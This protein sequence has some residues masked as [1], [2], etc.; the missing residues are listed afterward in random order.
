MLLTIP[1]S[2]FHFMCVLYE[3]YKACDVNFII[4]IAQ[5]V[6]CQIFL[7]TH[8]LYTQ[9]TH[10][11]F[12]HKVETLAQ[13]TVLQ[14]Q[15]KRMRWNNKLLEMQQQQMPM[16]TSAFVRGLRDICSSLA[17]TFLSLIK[18]RKS[19]TKMKLSRLHVQSDSCIK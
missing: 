19:L 11:H 16:L 6:C 14:L 1:K 9:L 4:S 3:V 8:A 15:M 7:T 12:V 2:I 5:Y 10:A 18:L 17:K 13:P